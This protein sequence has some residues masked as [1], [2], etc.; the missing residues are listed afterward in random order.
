MLYEV[1]TVVF[2]ADFCNPMT[3]EIISSSPEPD[4]NGFVNLCWD[5]TNNQSME[6]NFEATGT[7]PECGYPLGDEN[8]IFK[9][10]FDD[11]SP[12]QEGMGLSSVTHV[13]TERAGYNVTL[14]IEDTAS[15]HSNNNAFKKVRIPLLSDWVAEETNVVPDIV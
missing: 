11:G 8:V 5:F 1:I 3:V 2:Y 6:V 13:F 4:V 15:C 7:Y 9:W 14:I 12:I 10:N